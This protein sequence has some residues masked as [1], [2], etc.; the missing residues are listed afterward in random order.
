MFCPKVLPP[1]RPKRDMPWISEP[2]LPP[3][4]SPWFR[5]WLFTSSSNGSCRDRFH[6][7]PSSNDLTVR[8]LV[9]NAAG[10]AGRS[11]LIIGDH[12]HHP[13]AVWLPL[14]LLHGQTG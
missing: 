11:R 3:W 12:M 1:S 14:D 7:A 10:R 8:H 9:E 5:F 13:S 6:K 4:L 2:S